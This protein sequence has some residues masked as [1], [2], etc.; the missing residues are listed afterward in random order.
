MCGQ[1]TDHLA[2][3]LGVWRLRPS[4]TKLS[5]SCT[6]A[7]MHHFWSEFQPCEAG[8]CAQ[9][10]QAVS[11]R[12]IACMIKQMQTFQAAGST[13]LFRTKVGELYHYSANLPCRIRHLHTK[14]ARKVI[15]QL[16]MSRA[17]LKYWAYGELHFPGLF[18][19]KSPAEMIRIFYLQTVWWDSDEADCR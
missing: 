15:V 19:G 17:W 10:D 3:A 12:S 4:Q 7:A 1:F 13:N 11:L 14:Q 6:F 16:V 18:K 9:A 8:H 2:L 5:A